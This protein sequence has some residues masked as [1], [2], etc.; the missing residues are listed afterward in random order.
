MKTLGEQITRVSSGFVSWNAGSVMQVAWRERD[1]ASRINAAHEALEINPSCVPALIL[2]AEEES[3]T[4]ADAEQVLK[5]VVQS[6]NTFQ[7]GKH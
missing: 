6:T 7:S 5:F 4:V 3:E 2:L 1:S